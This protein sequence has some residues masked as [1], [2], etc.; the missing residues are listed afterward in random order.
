MFPFRKPA[1]SIDAKEAESFLPLKECD[2][3]RA[4]QVE[5][6]PRPR[7]YN[8]YPHFTLHFLLILG[9]SVAFF[10]ISISAQETGRFGT[11]LIWS[12]PLLEPLLLQQKISET[13]ADIFGKLQ[14]MMPSAGPPRSSRLIPTSQSRRHGCT[15]G[16]RIE[17]L[18]YDGLVC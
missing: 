10:W 12:E 6:L 7:I 8:L 5:L 16:L 13:Q 4:G 1:A 18:T 14:P 17:S 3:S 15:A 9:Y 11:S 2:D